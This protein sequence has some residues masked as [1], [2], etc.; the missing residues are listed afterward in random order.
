MSEMCVSKTCGIVPEKSAL[1]RGVSLQIHFGKSRGGVVGHASMEI[2][3]V[4]YWNKQNEGCI[5]HR[6]YD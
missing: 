3:L 6:L 1:S 5:G 4:V 2:A